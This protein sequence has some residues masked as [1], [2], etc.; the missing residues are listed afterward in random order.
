[1]YLILSTLLVWSLP[2]FAQSGHTYKDKMYIEEASEDFSELKRTTKVL[3]LELVLEQGLRK[4]YDEKIRK[5]TSTILLNQLSDTKDKFWF[6]NLNLVFKSDSQRV[7]TIFEGSNDNRTSKTPTGSFGLEVED[8]TIFNWGKDYLSFL[9]AKETIERSVEVQKEESRDLRQNLIL[10]YTKLLYLNE[11]VKL[12]KQQLRNASFVYRLNREKVPLKKVSKHGYYQSRSD[13]L[14]AQDEYYQ[15]KLDLE[16]ENENMAELLN[17]PAQI[18]Y[19]LNDEF[20]YTKIKITN[21]GA[22]KIAYENSP[23]LK[24]TKLNQRTTHRDYEIALRNNLPLPKISVD[25][26]S[27][28]HQFG[29]DSSTNYATNTG[30]SIEVVAS[31]NATWSIFG[32]GGLLNK[33][34]LANSRLS[35]RNAEIGHEA[36][37]RAVEKKIAKIYHQFR[38]IDDR[39]KILSSR[40]PSL[41]NRLDLALDSYLERKGNYTDFQLALYENFS[42]QAS[43]I[44]LKWNYFNLKVQLAQLI[45]VDE[46]PGEVFDRVVLGGKK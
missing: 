45:G 31:I 13:Y 22:F 32:D 42:T 19:V 38:N 17:D 37:R 10:T 40:V 11:V 44:E 33:R 27:Y 14:R 29:T 12:K 18:K 39:L 36:T 2:A 26:G 5:N 30:N 25:L 34:T 9:N 16:M 15:A 6:P 8:Y 4:N 24:T 35:M 20:K 3:N 28:K 1:M 23:F 7:G 46:L 21:N 41:K 43:E